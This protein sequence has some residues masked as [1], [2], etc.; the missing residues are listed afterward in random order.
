MKHLDLFSGIGGFSLAAQWVWGD[1]HEIVCFVEQDAFCQKVLKQHWPEVAIVE[2]VRDVRQIVEITQQQRLEKSR[3]FGTGVFVRSS[4]T[5]PSEKREEKEGDAKRPDT[6]ATTNVDLLTGGFPC[7]GFSVAGKQRGKADDRYLWPAMFE[8]I[9]AVR[10]CWVIGENVA[11]IVNMALDTVLSDL[12]DQ[13]YATQTFIIPAC[14][15]NAPHRRDRVWM[16]AHTKRIGSG[17]R[18]TECER[19]QRGTSFIS[20]GRNVADTKNGNVTRVL[21][22]QSGQSGPGTKRETYRRY[23]GGGIGD[24]WTVEPNVDRVAHGIPNR[25]DRLKSLGNAMVPQIVIPIMKAIKALTL[26]I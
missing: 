21:S 11:G 4:E 6:G 12:E 3:T 13:G 5:K 19:Q 14:A 24:Q 18:W 17:S 20:S 1:E 7:Q 25:V 16:V 22:L 23:S 15:Q 10:P 2:D 26:E 9:K 8:V